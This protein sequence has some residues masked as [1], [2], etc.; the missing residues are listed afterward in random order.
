MRTLDYIHLDASKVSTVVNE[1]QQLLADFQLFYTNLRGFHWNITGKRFFVL[2]SKFEEMYDDV[3]GKVDELAERILMLD[4]TPEN[5]YSEYIKVSRVK[6][7]TAV[8]CANEALEN[9]LDTLGLLIEKER[10][11]LSLASDANDEG[12]VSL[13]SDYLKEQ[14]KLVWMLVAYNSRECKG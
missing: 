3:A 8:S 2:H 11:I 1:L 10:S 4:G 7:M 5:R 13:M 9:V 6:E 14:E 12:T